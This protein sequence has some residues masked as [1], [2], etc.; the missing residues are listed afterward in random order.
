MRDYTSIYSIKEFYTKEILPLYFDD[1]KLAL[2]NIGLLGMFMDIDSSVTEDQMNIMGRYINEIMPGKAELPD[3]IYANAA[4]YGITDIFATPAKMSMLLFIKENDVLSCSTVVENHKEFTL[5]ADATILIE[6]EQASEES[7]LQYSLPYNVKI[8]TSYYNGE[9][10]H[11]SFY[12]T[13]Y[14][15][16]AVLENLPFIKTMKTLIN[17]DVWLALRVHVYQY[18]R[19]SYVE[20]IVTNSKLNIPYIDIKFTNQLC[21]FEA[22]YTKPGSSKMVQLEK[23][24]YNSNAVTNPFIYYRITGNDS[25]RFSFANDDRYFIPD[26]NSN[27]LIKIYE[28]KGQAGVFGFRADGYPVTIRAN[29]EDESIAYNRNIFPQGACQGD[30]VGGRD[31]L[32]LDQLKLITTEHQRTV[33]SYTTDED[34]NSYFLNFASVFN[35]DAIFVKQR[36]DYAGREFGCFIRIGDG[37]NIS[38]TNTLCIR[39]QTNETDSHFESLRQ[40]NVKPGH[41]YIYED[42]NTTT[43]LNRCPDDMIIEPDT[44]SYTSMALMVISVR[45]NK[46][47]YYMNSVNKLVELNYTYFN[48]DSMFTFIA[49]SCRLYRNAINGE[50]R[51]KV[52]LTLARVDGVFNDLQSDDFQLQSPNGELDVSKLKVLMIFDTSTGN[53]IELQCI[54][55]ATEQGEFRYIF[56][57]DLTTNDMIDDNRILITN[58]LKRKDGSNDERILDMINP[59]IQFT[60]FYD[61]NDGSGGNHRFNDIALVQNYTLCNIFTPIDNEFYFAYPLTLIRSHV[62][63]EDAPTSELGFN[64]YIKQVPLIGYDFL[65]NNANVEKILTDIRTEHIFLQNI[66]QQLHGAFTINMKFYNT[67]GRS[68]SFYIGYGTDR[69]LINHVNCSLHIGIKFYEGILEEEYVASI[70]QYIKKYIEDV[71]HLNGSNQVYISQLEHNL[72]AEFKD[73][74]KYAIFYNINHYDT[75]YQVIEMLYDINGQPVPDFV[76]E[77]LTLLT[78]DV[79]VTGL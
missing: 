23:R 13:D 25:I 15:N 24:L 58:L 48:L 64:F 12:D 44:I 28:T 30:S 42:E 77:Y 26:Y 68:R 19:K 29:T 1:S 36:D 52:T 76:P 72:H 60:V 27:I 7:A 50:D 39:L 69:E 66:V 32:T 8:R 21:N 74:I 40:Y 61:Y 4:N 63:F 9:Y 38:P 65:H 33:K 55:Q 6:D 17:G 49:D 22:F 43:V 70:R 11:I 54:E 35:H 75:K 16:D 47:N 46:V 73:Q 20:P 2:S 5:D 53:Y 78:D 57:I 41:R 14:I 79:T 56:E 31:Q 34:L 10:N 51:Y 59:G 71:N 3:F 67:Y 45:P 18:I 62:I 37:T